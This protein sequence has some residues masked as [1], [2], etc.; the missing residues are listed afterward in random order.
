MLINRL[1]RLI[2]L[3][4]QL[5][6]S[7]GS[8]EQAYGIL[9][10]L[11]PPETIQFSEKEPNVNSYMTCILGSLRLPYVTIPT[12]IQSSLGSIPNNP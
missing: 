6:L 10:F 8:L 7:L 11:F 3:T 5:A 2:A 12:S 1:C 4:G 9:R